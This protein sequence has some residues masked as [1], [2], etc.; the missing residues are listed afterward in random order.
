MSTSYYLVYDFGDKD[1][2]GLPKITEVNEKKIFEILDRAHANDDDAA[3]KKIAV[4]KL[5]NCL[6]DWS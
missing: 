1:V 4:Y 5:G 6:I 2:E 3:M